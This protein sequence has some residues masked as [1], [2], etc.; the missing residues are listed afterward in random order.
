MAWHAEVDFAL[1]VVSVRGS[2]GQRG[3]RG[4]ELLEMGK[5]L[6][7][8]VAGCDP[9]RWHHGVGEASRPSLYEYVGWSTVLN[10]ICCCKPN[11]N[12]KLN[13]TLSPV[14]TFTSKALSPGKFVPLINL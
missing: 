8:R 10:C 7:W 4:Q 6:A 5:Q 14:H 13:R 9:S 12:V 1:W 3:Q 11:C 2:P